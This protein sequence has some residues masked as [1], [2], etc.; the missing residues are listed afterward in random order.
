M[1]V[2]I[3]DKLRY[4][5]AVDPPGPAQPTEEQQPSVDWVCEQIARRHLTA[6]ALV[7]LEMS[8]PLNWVAAQGLHVFAPG[9]WAIVKQQTYQ[10]YKHFAAFLEKRGSVEYLTRRVEHFEQVYERKEEATKGSERE[11][12]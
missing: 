10:D 4:A 9:V 7:G 2:G 5:F 12:D 11:Q 8:R 1:S 3:L 6:P